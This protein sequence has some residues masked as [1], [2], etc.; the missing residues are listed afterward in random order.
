MATPVS[1]HVQ[2]LADPK[3]ARSLTYVACAH[4]VDPS[5]AEDIARE[6]IA[7]AYEAPDP[8]ASERSFK[9]WIYRI[10]RCRI[11]DAFR[12][13]AKAP[14]TERVPDCD[15]FPC[16][17]EP[18]RTLLAFRWLH[19]RIQPGTRDDQVLGWILRLE[20]DGDL[21]YADIAREESMTDAAVRK[22]VSRLQRK[23]RTEWYALIASYGGFLG[24]VGV[25][26]ALA[27]TLVPVLARRPD[28]IRPDT[29]TH[30]V[31]VRDR[32]AQLR[33]EAVDACRAAQWQDC[34]DK[35]DEARDLD[36]NAEAGD[37]EMRAARSA[38][39]NAL[40]PHD[41]IVPPTPPPP[42]PP[43]NDKMPR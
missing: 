32:F 4:N 26:V 17:R 14:P 11:F 30:E 7:D 43:R 35:L 21:T 18:R 25:V 16:T 31:V 8:P 22:A 19:R 38:A 37:P 33:R 39:V 29:R 34:L 15:I 1:P 40:T 9:P 24:V 3:L 10:L 13:K 36:G 2:R 42:P 6:T 27:L 20:A 41:R 23:L 5:E 28:D 12:K